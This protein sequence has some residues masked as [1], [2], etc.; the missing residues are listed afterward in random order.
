[1]PWPLKIR[2]TALLITRRGSRTRH[3][4]MIKP[5]QL[6]QLG[7]RMTVETIK[8]MHRCASSAPRRRHCMIGMVYRMSSMPDRPSPTISLRQ[9]RRPETARAVVALMLPVQMM[10]ML[11]RTAVSLPPGSPATH[12]ECLP[13]VPPRYPNRQSLEN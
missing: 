13:A 1:M 3:P 5:Q 2:T 6:A 10:P 8:Q 12:L 9:R 7:P 11:R 4:T